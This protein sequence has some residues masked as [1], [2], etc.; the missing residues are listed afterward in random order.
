MTALGTRRK[1]AP[2][3]AGAITN[4]SAIRLFTDPVCEWDDRMDR[5]ARLSDRFHGLA[6]VQIG[7]VSKTSARFDTRLRLCADCA[8]NPALKHR[9]TPE[10]IEGWGGA[11]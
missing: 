5:P 8:K 9:G 11:R 1:W 3:A 6:T 7:R 2:Q 4:R 10:P